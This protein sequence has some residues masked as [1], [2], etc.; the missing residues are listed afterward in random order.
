ME[1]IL[2]K[3]HISGGARRI[4]KEKEKIQSKVKDVSPL[5]LYIHFCAHNRNLILIDSIKS[6]FDAVS[7]FGTLESL[8]TFL[9]SSLPRLHMFEEEQRKQVEGVVLTLRKLSETRW[10]SHKRAVDSVYISLPAIVQTLRQISEG[11]IPNSKLKAVSEAQGLLFQV[12]IFKF[13]F[14]LVMWKRILKKCIFYQIIS[15]ILQFA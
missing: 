8:Y 11:N 15:K 2:K 5:A 13:T 10:S 4:L 14:L 3:V 1:F 12:K 7:F 9:T 6:S